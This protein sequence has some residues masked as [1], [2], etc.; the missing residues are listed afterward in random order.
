MAMETKKQ[1]EKQRKNILN[2]I[3]KTGPILEGQLGVVNRIC[4]NKGCVCRKDKDKRHPA[5]YL[6]W[7][8][9][10]KTQAIYIPVEKQEEAKLWNSNFKEV[11]NH[12]KEASE[13]SKK[14]LKLRDK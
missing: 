3:K 14:I 1:L 8:E 4:G 13:I 10:Y 2:I 11:K 9:N 6:T 5:M 12:L 7:R